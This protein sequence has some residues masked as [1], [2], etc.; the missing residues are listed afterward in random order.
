[1]ILDDVQQIRAVGTL[2][3]LPSDIEFTSARVI[4]AA[5]EEGLIGLAGFLGL[6]HQLG[7]TE[8]VRSSPENPS[9]RL[10]AAGGQCA[11][12]GRQ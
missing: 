3:E 6:S 7:A 11:P 8:I 9:S 5:K 10:Q 1:M 2:V 12:D 4:D